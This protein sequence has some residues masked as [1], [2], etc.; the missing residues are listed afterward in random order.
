MVLSYDYWVTRFARDPKV[1]GKKILVNNYPMTIV[2]V[3]RRG[4]PALDPARSPQIRVPILMKPVITPDWHWLHMD[5]R[6]TR[7][8]QVFARLKPGYTIESA[9]RR[10]RCCSR[11]F[12]PYEMT[13]PAAK[14]WSAY[15]REQFMKGKLLVE[16]RRDRLFRRCATTSRRRS[17]S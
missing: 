15:S 1:I 12:G 4:S 6:R 10:C 13:L 7:W 11:R 9:R 3:S 16:Q 17:W 2:G 8:V 5:D 14:D